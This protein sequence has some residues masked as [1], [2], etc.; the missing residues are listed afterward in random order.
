MKKG[1]PKLA[2]CKI[3]LGQD[4]NW[5]VQETSDPINWDPIDGLGIVDPKQVSYILES[6]YSLVEYGL[7][8]STI[9]EAFYKFYISKNLGK[10]MVYLERV[11]ESILDSN[12]T[13]FA[14]PDTLDEEKGAYADFLNQLTQARIKMLNDLIDFEEH[15]T[16]EELEE[17]IREQCSLDYMEGNPIHPFDEILA[18]LEYIPEG[19]ELDEEDEDSPQSLQK[20]DIDEEEFPDIEEEE[21]IEEDE[22]MQWDRDEEEEDYEERMAYGDFSQEDEDDEDEEEEDT[23]RKAKTKKMPSVAKAKN[24]APKSKKT[25]AQQSKAT[26]K[27]KK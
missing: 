22:T 7:R 13:L 8:L 6:A 17:N 1:S 18:I 5:W 16:V 11:P 12:E 21:V 23:P 19:Y 24:V 3:K 2:W 15:L 27:K 20:D 14:L 26:T 25:Q 10:G 9:D 4:M